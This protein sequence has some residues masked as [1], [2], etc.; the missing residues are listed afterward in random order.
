M[1][2]LN[3]DTF[4]TFAIQNYD[5]IQCHSV[6][7]FEDDLKRFLYIK[8]LFTRYKVNGDL[9]ER[10]ILNHLIVLYNI[11]GLSATRMLFHKIEQE[12][13]SILTTFLLYLERMPEQ[14]PDSNIMLSDVKLDENV[15]SV[16]RNI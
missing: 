16:L 11:F 8:K 1:I 2:A 4:M 13:W 10:L 3:D 12:D 7:E 9:K 15:I 5:N 6:Q 14:I